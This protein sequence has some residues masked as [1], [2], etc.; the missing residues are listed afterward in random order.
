M[1]AG[2]RDRSLQRPTTVP[3]IFGN[4]YAASKTTKNGRAVRHTKAR[5]TAISGKHGASSGAKPRLISTEHPSQ[6]TPP[7]PP[8]RLS[9]REQQTAVIGTP[10]DK[11]MF[12]DPS[13][14][15]SLAA[16]GVTADGP[17][18]ERLMILFLDAL[19]SRDESIQKL[20]ARLRCIERHHEGVGF[21]NQ[22]LY[23]AGSGER[24][25][26]DAGIEGGNTGLEG[27]PPPLP[28][29]RLRTPDSVNRHGAIG[30]G[31]SNR[32][33]QSSLS[34]CKGHDEKDSAGA[35]A[36]SQQQQGALTSGDHQDHDCDDLRW[37]LEVERRDM[38]RR[39]DSMKS[40]MERVIGQFRA[41]AERAE[42]KAAAAEERAR[43]KA[44]RYFEN[45]PERNRLR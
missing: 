39:L 36:T 38:R 19:E 1:A 8:P 40:E 12:G 24:E 9:R 6:P 26:T 5:T 21:H 11:S 29:R 20:T 23:G 28:A 35:V 3:S 14:G 10:S 45:N 22:P 13:T 17:D 42:T 15:T 16:E 37:K 41:R 30:W 32:S 7:I 2:V 4:G 31:A 34:F 44:F 27:T 18:V 33:Q 43:M 25:P